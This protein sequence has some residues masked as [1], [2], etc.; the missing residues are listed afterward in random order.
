MD[1]Y[2]PK[3]TAFLSK[4]QA[5]A[6]L[7]V[8]PREY[9]ALVAAGKIHPTITVNGT[10]K[11]PLVEI[12][13]LKG[14]YAAQALSVPH[15]KFVRALTIFCP[16]AQ[17]VNTQL[18]VADLPRVPAEYIERLRID[19]Q[20][21]PEPGIIKAS[22][23][24]DFF[25]A[26]GRAWEILKHPDLRLL[27]EL[28]HMINRGEEEIRQTIRAKYGR[29][30]GPE[31]VARYIEYFFNWRIM[32][33]DSA[34]FYFK[35]LPDKGREQILKQCAFRRAD[36]FIFYALGIDYGGEVA[37]LLEKSCLGLLH[38]LN[39]YVDGFVYGDLVVGQSDIQRLADIISTL[40]GAA[41]QVRAGRVPKG[42]QGDL[43]ENMVPRAYSRDQFFESEKSVT[44]NPQ[45]PA[46]G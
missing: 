5:I 37:D 9:N 10:N 28:L 18:G 35:L 13:A 4:R 2:G 17:D 31:D 26:L 3:G 44:F 32:D 43:V 45:G 38:K 39:I 19:V 11:I 23:A 15:E 21:D 20:K 1:L 14:E 6:M 36:Y 41:S 27:T 7:G 16:S 42:K 33:P 30:Y 8:T 25:A 40:L 34:Q 24:R 29:E 46:N 12:I 22:G